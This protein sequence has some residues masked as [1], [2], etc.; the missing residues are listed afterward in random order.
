MLGRFV[1]LRLAQGLITLLVA[2]FVV[3]AMGRLTGNPADTML[4]IEATAAD[5]EAFI[6]R[7]GLDRP[8]IV[9]YWVYLKHASQGDFGRSL[10]NNYPVTELVGVYM[11]NS[12]K[13][14]SAA[15]VFVI[16]VSI[17]LGVVSAV[18]RGRLWDKIAMTV[19]LLGQSLPPFWTGIMAVML[20]GVL[21]GWLPTAGIGGWQYYVLPATTMGLTIVAGV[22]RL[23]RSSMLEVLDAEY[24]KLARAKGVAEGVVVWKH[25]LRNALIPVVTYIG[26]MYGLIVAAAITTEVVFSWPGLGR[27]TFEALLTRDF[28]LLQFA[29]LTWAALIIAINYVVDLTYLILDPRIRL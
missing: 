13:L 23:L 19:A 1:L 15:M 22:V 3:F 14:A 7:M 5:R 11:V 24:V 12:L 25:A 26:F 6:E 4:P 16:L 20:F 18:Y 21:L 8:V 17:P 9:Q 28:P 29:V 27:A 2:S 10:R